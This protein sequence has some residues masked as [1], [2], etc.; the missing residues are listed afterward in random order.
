MEREVKLVGIFLI[1]KL[2]RAKIL[3]R[4]LGSGWNGGGLRVRQLR[5]RWLQ[6]RRWRVERPDSPA[7]R[8]LTLSRG[9]SRQAKINFNLSKVVYILIHTLVE[10]A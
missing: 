9:H 8:L 10:G 7:C 5:V 4:I 2:R 6:V 1:I 3:L